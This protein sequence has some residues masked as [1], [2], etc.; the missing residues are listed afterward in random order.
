MTSLKFTI[1]QQLNSKIETAIDKGLEV[2]TIQVLNK[3]KLNCPVG[4]GKATA[5]HLRDNIFRK[6]V[7]KFGYIFTNVFYAPYVEYAAGKPSTK[8]SKNK[9]FM[10]RALF[11]DYKNLISLFQ[12]AMRQ[13]L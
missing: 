11:D 10:R 7:G 2:V 13:Y 9:Y 6:V 8:K 5:G 4:D 12:K 1:N 3:A